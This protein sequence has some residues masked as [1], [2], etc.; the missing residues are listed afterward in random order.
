MTTPRGLEGVEVDTTAVSLVDGAN[1]ALSYRGIPI[2]TLIHRPFT[3]VAYLVLTG[4]DPDARTLAQF[5][6]ELNRAS[7]LTDDDEHGLRLVAR[8]PLHPMQA[9]IALAPLLT[10]TDGAFAQFGDAARGVSIAARLPAVLARLL[11]LRHGRSAPR[12]AADDSDPNARFL[13]AIGCPSDARLIRAFNVTQILQIEHGFNA[14]T[15]AA[16]VIASTLAPVENALAGAFG[17]LHG[18]LHGGADEA[19]LAMA[20]QVGSPEAAAAYVDNCLARHVKIM[21]MGHREY[22]VLDPRARYVKA[23]ASE[24]AADSPLA[25]TAATLVAIESHMA[26]RMRAKGKPVHANLEFYKG[27]VYRAV[28]L[29]PDFFT[30]AFALARVFGYVAHFIESRVDN[31]LIRPAARYV[32]AVPIPG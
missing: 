13:A 5:E 6:A 18:K 8:L 31:R 26:R 17:A 21:G 22:R 27:V 23:F 9:L 20:E 4:T 14:S 1:G 25:N 24:L 30:P 32:G 29:P 7:P 15:F 19:A 12:F 10:H 16:R 11:A 28:G 3:R 2:E